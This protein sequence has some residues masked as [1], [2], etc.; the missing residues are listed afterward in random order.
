[1]ILVIS[2]LIELLFKKP[3]KNIK[4]LLNL[5][6]KDDDAEEELPYEYM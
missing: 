6:S 4:G 2:K 1:M 3:V 5:K